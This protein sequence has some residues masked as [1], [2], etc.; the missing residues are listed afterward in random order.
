MLIC[1]CM[2]KVVVLTE[3]SYQFYIIIVW[4]LIC[5]YNFRN[6]CLYIRLLINCFIERVFF[7]RWN[8][9]S[10][11]NFDIIIKMCI[12]CSLCQNERNIVQFL[13][14]RNNA[15]MTFKIGHLLSSYY[16][17]FIRKKKIEMDCD[18]NYHKLPMKIGVRAMGLGEG[19][20]CRP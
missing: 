2:I 8:V 19:D 9:F 18:R 4:N 15:F 17:L 20:G 12:K 6:D 16:F 3:R 7:F 5:I 1:G 14:L 13:N 11:Q 10:K